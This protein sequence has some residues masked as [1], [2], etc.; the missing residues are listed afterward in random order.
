MLCSTRS[1]ICFLYGGRRRHAGT[2]PR[3]QWLSEP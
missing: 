3:F 1:T 2:F